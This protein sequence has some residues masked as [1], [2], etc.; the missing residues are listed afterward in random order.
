MFKKPVS[1]FVLIVLI[2]TFVLSGCRQ[3]E[4]K[5][6]PLSY[7][8]I[9]LT[10]YKMFDD[11]DVIEPIINDYE[12]AHPGLKIHYRKFNNFTEYQNTILN[13]MAEGEGPD[14]F[15][16]Q[17][18]WF[19]SNYRKIS[20]L[21]EKAAEGGT[22]LEGF[23]DTFVDVAFKDLV[24]VDDEGRSQVYALPMTVDTLALYYNKAHFDDRVPT[25]GKPSTTWE[26]IKE[27]IALLNKPDNSLERFEVA[28]MAMGRAD[29]ISR[30]VDILYL[31][32]LQFG[33]QFYND[34]ISEAIF[35]GQ[36]GNVYTYPGLAALEFFTSFADS[37]Q[38]HYSWNEL[39]IDDDTDEKE[40]EA[41]AQGK[42]SMIM[43]FAYTHDEIVNQ[44]NVFKSKGIKT[45]DESDIKIALAPQLYD[46]AVSTEKRITYANYFA[47]TVSRN[48]EYSDIAWDFLLELTSKKNLQHYFEKLHKPTSRRDM[49]ED[50]KKD[51]VYGVFASQIGY[52]ESFPILD[53]F[54]YKEI[55]TDVITKA[56]T[57]GA[58]RSD[59]L[60]AQEAIT[61]MLFNLAPD[62]LVKPKAEEKDVE[63][64][65]GA[66]GDED[67]N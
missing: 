28:G 2:S 53:Y 41:F 47:E 50:Q 7:D 12:A 56:N 54:T 21:P 31:L 49:I 66:D 23:E 22:V 11:G 1:L 14:I 32:F 19:A 48:S 64:D 3:K 39:I 62:G 59:L 60:T 61:R 43:G 57:S 38:K 36:Q 25:R 30:G 29:N 63:I 9:E 35:A 44:I 33:V 42:V 65:S 37:D 4:A 51:P 26:G 27:D 10:Y 67:E 34:N 24:R 52:A 6:K 55:F 17:N 16:M 15:S 8:G 18:T 20:P 13:E 58:G 5:K 40:I 45:I 46:P